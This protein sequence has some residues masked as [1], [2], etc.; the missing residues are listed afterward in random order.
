MADIRKWSLVLFLIIAVLLPAACSNAA[1]NTSTTTQSTFTGPPDKLEILY[2]HGPSRCGTCICFE[3][4]ITD[5]L[6]KYFAAESAA[7]KISFNIYDYSDAANADLAK[8]Y[9]SVSSTLY[10]NSIKNGSERIVNVIEIWQWNC[11]F[12]PEEFRES[13]RDA[14]VKTLAGER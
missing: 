1:V 5:V 4:A 8:K 9:Q 10:F 12:K 13:L 14:I 6:Q 7:G 3:E 2:F 11:I